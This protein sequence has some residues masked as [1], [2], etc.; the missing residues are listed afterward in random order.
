MRASRIRVVAFM[1]EGIMIMADCIL[2][3]R[4]H[5]TL[6]IREAARRIG[7]SEGVLRRIEIGKPMRLQTFVVILYWMLGE[8]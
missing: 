8:S 6:T 7:I 4:H 2:A 5:N 1:P 3:W